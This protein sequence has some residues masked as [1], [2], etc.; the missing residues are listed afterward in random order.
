[1]RFNDW[2]ARLVEAVQSKDNEP[3][4]FG[5]FDCCAA[6]AYVVKEVHGIDL[7]KGLRGYRSAAGAARTIK[8]NG[9]TL[10]E[11][12]CRQCEKVGWLEKPRAFA[13]R[14][15]LVVADIQSGDGINEACGVVVGCTAVFPSDIGWT[16]YP[17]TKCKAVFGYE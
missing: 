17:I 14:G 12:V 8:K 13:M 7:M 6:A 4:S 1:M 9:G 11:V 15:D 16:H 3:F 2:E 5:S 10:Y